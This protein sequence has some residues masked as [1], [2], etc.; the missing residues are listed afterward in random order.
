M[1]QQ[2]TQSNNL[3]TF[4]IVLVLLTYQMCGL[5][6][7]INYYIFLYINYIY[8][9]ISIS[10]QSFPSLEPLVCSNNTQLECCDPVIQ[11]E[12][13]LCLNLLEMEKLLGI[14][15]MVW[16]GIKYPEIDV[17]ENI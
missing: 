4:P 10:K 5:F 2:I 14:K 15:D 17:K 12:V 11:A 6:L 9:Y 7:Y 16:G 3:I 1:T 13:F 8:F